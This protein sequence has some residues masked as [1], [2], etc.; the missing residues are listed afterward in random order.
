M[1]GLSIAV[2]EAQS[3]HVPRHLLLPLTSP[4]F[5]LIEGSNDC[6]LSSGLVWACG[7]TMLTVPLMLVMSGDFR[8]LHTVCLC[9]QAL[10][11]SFASALR[12]RIYRTD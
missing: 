2:R 10:R 5:A 6:R 8:E 1:T 9:E 3:L 4:G 7:L 11:G 12:S